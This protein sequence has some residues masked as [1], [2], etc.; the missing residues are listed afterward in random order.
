MQSIFSSLSSKRDWK[1]NGRNRGKENTPDK[2]EMYCSGMVR[3]HGHQG[4]KCKPVL[5]LRKFTVYKTGRGLSSPEQ[6]M[7]CKAGGGHWA[8][9]S[10]YT[11]Q[12]KHEEERRRVVQ[13]LT[14]HAN[15][16]LI[17]GAVRCRCCPCPVLISTAGSPAP[18][19]FLLNPRR[20]GF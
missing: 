5:R 1:N 10:H 16:S 8:A 14:L 9:R 2:Q 20:Q 3:D 13:T 18:S 12:V 15:L 4:W 11:G 7:Q 6:E 19:F 17:P